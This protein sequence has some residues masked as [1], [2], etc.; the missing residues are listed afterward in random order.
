MRKPF[1]EALNTAQQWP[2]SD[3]RQG[4]R[5]EMMNGSKPGSSS[6]RDRTPDPMRTRCVLR[7]FPFPSPLPADRCPD[8]SG[9]GR[10]GILSSALACRTATGSRTVWRRLS[11][12]PRERAGVRGNRTR[13]NP[14]SQTTPRIVKL[15]EPPRYGRAFLID[16]RKLQ[17][18]NTSC[19]LGELGPWSLGFLWSLVFGAWMFKLGSPRRPQ[20]VAI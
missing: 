16:Q 17:P 19:K 5:L 14:A 9:L 20:S 10:G 3:L 1:E 18:P 11:L 13:L 6:G 2:V 4:R 7:A 8:W 12:S 15:Q